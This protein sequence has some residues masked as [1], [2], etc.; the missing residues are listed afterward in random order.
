MFSRRVFNTNLYLFYKGGILIIKKLLS[1]ILVL[2]ITFIFSSY[3]YATQDIKITIDGKQLTFFSGEAKP[4]ESN[5]KVLIPMRKIFEALDFYVQYDSSTQSIETQHI[6]GKLPTCLEMQIGNKEALVNRSYTVNLD[7]APQFINE[8]TYVPLRFVAEIAYANV[9]WNSI[10]RTVEITKQN[11]IKLDQYVDEN[12]PKEVQI[13]EHTLIID[14][15]R[16]DYIGISS[17]YYS[18]YP[19]IYIYINDQEDIDFLV[20]ANEEERDAIWEVLGQMAYECGKYYNCN[21]TIVVWSDKY[22]TKS[23]DD[24]YFFYDDV[25][26]VTYTAKDGMISA[27]WYD[28]KQ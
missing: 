18:R 25:L 11:I 3:A 16:M 12:I 17:D 6:S 26:S 4:I 2:G 8:V 22:G 23:D 24:D 5:G 13:G 28:L 15:A 7:V 10:T 20:N 1:L 21:A 19:Y 14:K 9:N 27:Y